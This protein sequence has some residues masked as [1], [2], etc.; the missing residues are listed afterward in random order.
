MIWEYLKI[1]CCFLV[2]IAEFFV[3]YYLLGEVH[4]R[5]IYET[6]NKWE[7]RIGR[8]MR[9]YEKEVKKNDCRRRSR[10]NSTKVW[11]DKGRGNGYAFQIN[12]C[13]K[14]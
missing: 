12:R 6:E 5:G 9:L 3:W 4:L 1:V 2:I 7:E 8:E 11:N 10:T 14:K 13:V